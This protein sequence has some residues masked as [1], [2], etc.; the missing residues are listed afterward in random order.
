MKFRRMNP[1]VRDDLLY[2][3][4]GVVPA[5][6]FASILWCFCYFRRR[7]A[8]R[9]QICARKN[10]PVS[11][12]NQWCRLSPP[13]L[14]S[15]YQTSPLLSSNR[16]LSFPTRRAHDEISRSP[17]S[18]RP[19]FDHIKPFSPISPPPRALNSSSAPDIADAE[20]PRS[21]LL[22]SP[23][24][25]VTSVRRPNAVLPLPPVPSTHER[26]TSQEAGIQRR[27]FGSIGCTTVVS[28]PDSTC[29][30]V[31]PA[32]EEARARKYEEFK[33][34]GKSHWEAMAA[35]DM[36]AGTE[37]WEDFSVAGGSPRRQIVSGVPVPLRVNEREKS[38]VGR[39]SR[40]RGMF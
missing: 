22:P 32:F 16:P 37:C 13:L 20:W 28:E 4:M 6:I 36:S 35:S 21:P 27:Y 23:C 1:T 39:L 12:C 9:A 10:T 30:R 40:S 33:R 31:N 29:L 5:L 24:F 38:Q 11:A 19:I 8:R 18:H 26:P 25:F 2:A 14:P 3:L 34:L 7:K 15:P 17:G